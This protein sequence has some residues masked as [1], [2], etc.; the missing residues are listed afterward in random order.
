MQRLGFLFLLVPMLVAYGYFRRRFSITTSRAKELKLGDDRMV[1]TRQPRS[2]AGS[3]EGTAAASIGGG[4]FGCL[5]RPFT[6]EARLYTPNL[7]VVV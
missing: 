2:L 1:V 6:R 5:K 7:G 3:S 4:A